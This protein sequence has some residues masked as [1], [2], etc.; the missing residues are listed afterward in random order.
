MRQVDRLHDDG[1][2]VVAVLALTEDLE[3]EVA[4]GRGEE[5]EGQDAARISLRRT[6]SSTLRIAGRTLGSRPAATSR[7]SASTP[8]MLRPLARELRTV[9]RGVLK[10]AR[11][12]SKKLSR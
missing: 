8:L 10:P 7:A 12:V 3:C 5:V 1:D 9:F 6:Q 11:T 4:L 2:L